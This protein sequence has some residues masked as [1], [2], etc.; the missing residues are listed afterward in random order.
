MGEVSMF[1]PHKLRSSEG[2]ECI[3]SI[4]VLSHDLRMLVQLNKEPLSAMC[5][6]DI[7]CELTTSMGMVTLI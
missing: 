2:N 1:K 7:M 3:L 4:C 5:A 6:H